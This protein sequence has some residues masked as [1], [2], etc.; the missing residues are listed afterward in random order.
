MTSMFWLLGQITINLLVYCPDC[1]HTATTAVDN[2]NKEEVRWENTLR[3]L[4]TKNYVLI[5]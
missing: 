2:F 4:M 1:L 3:E 5:V